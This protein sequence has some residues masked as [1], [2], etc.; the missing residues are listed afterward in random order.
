MPTLALRHKIIALA[1]GL[2]LLSILAATALLTASASRAVEAELGTRAMSVARTVAQVDLVKAELELPSS[3]QVIQ[4]VAERMR[5]ATG[6]AYIVILDME[7]TRHSHPLEDRLGTRFD[8]G[9][10][11]P[12]LAEQAYTSRARGVQGRSVRAFVP[13]MSVDGREQV[14]VVVVG[15]LVPGMPALLEAYMAELALAVIVA[16]AVGVVGASLLADNIK[17]QMFNLEPAE[18]ARR[19]EERTAAFGAITEGLIAIDTQDRITVINQEARRILRLSENT[20]VVGADIFQV[21]PYS[22]LP[23]V[24]KTGQGARNQ[25]MLFGRTVILTNRLPIHVKGQIV[26]AIATFRDRTE[27][28]KL[29]D[30]L[31]GVTQFVDALRAQNHEWMNKLHTIAGMIQLKRHDQALDYIFSTTEEQQALTRFL[32]RSVRDSRVAGLLLGKVTR[33]RELGIT[34]EIDRQSRLDLI[35]PP[36]QASDLVLILGNLL[37]NAMD[38]LAAEPVG[39]GRIDCLLHGDAEAVAIRVA[40]NGTGLPVGQPVTRIFEQGFSTKGGDN[41]GIGLA[42]V[43]EVVDFAGGEVQVEQGDGETVFQVWLPGGVADAGDSRAGGR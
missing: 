27:V 25:Q 39:S 9:D 11:G 8:G 32:A 10:E 21:I 24:I 3:T 36:L 37:E 16:V 38:A 4:S 6:V 20:P 29:A 23:E 26:G 42:L 12:A 1:S 43:R 31:T 2:V 17:R 33:A 30:E 22:R 19:L 34:L 14:G 40:D 41:R 5:L 28:Q 35:P 7:R 18:I 13:V 15:I